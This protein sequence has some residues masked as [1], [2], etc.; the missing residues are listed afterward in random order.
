MT[1]TRQFSEPED[2]PRGPK[3]TWPQT[4][5]IPRLTWGEPAAYCC[6]GLKIP[7]IQRVSQRGGPR[8]C[9]LKRALSGCITW[10]VWNPMTDKSLCWTHEETEAPGGETCSSSARHSAADGAEAS[11]PLPLPTHRRGAHPRPRAWVQPTWLCLVY[12]EQGL[13]LSCFLN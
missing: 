3:A 12:R 9:T 4:R 8:N 1:G 7:R 2:N 6:V 11:A 10:P 5:L 13:P